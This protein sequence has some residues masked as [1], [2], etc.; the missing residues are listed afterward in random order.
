MTLLAWEKFR[1]SVFELC[2]Y[3]RIYP[4]LAGNARSVRELH[5]RIFEE[6]QRR[7]ALA[8]TRLPNGPPHYRNATDDEI[9]EFQNY[10]RERS[11]VMHRAMMEVL[12]IVGSQ[13]NL[14]IQWSIIRTN[15]NTLTGFVRLQ[16]LEQNLKWFDDK[17]D[18]EFM[19]RLASQTHPL[20]D[21]LRLQEVDQSSSTASLGAALKMIQQD[22]TRPTDEL[23]TKLMAGYT[24]FGSS[25]LVGGQYRSEFGHGKVQG[26]QKAAWEAEEALRW[27]KV[28][29]EN[30]ERFGWPRNATAPEV[31]F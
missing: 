1:D 3:D 6:Y 14:Q 30:V 11:T 7:I 25:G 5:D 19:N 23:R 22:S 13:Y 29:V 20:T 4:G 24:A 21:F 2:S 27:L 8:Q 18:A 9:A 10:L 16:R 28:H 15:W 17:M 31:P 12:K 26:H